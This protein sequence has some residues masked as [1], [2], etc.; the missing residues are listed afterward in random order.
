MLNALREKTQGL[1][2]MAL[3]VILVVPF[4]LWG[5]SSYFGGSSTVYVARGHGLRITGPEFET[6]L[7][8]QRAALE[9]AFGKNLNP[10]LLGGQKFKKAVLEG[11]INK[12]LLLSDAKK[13]G[14]TTNPTEL[15]EEIRS[16]PAF[17][18]KGHFNAARYQ[19]LLADQGFTVAA[20]ERRVRDLTLLNQ[21][22]VG[23]L[24]S[25]F[26]PAPVLEQAAAL[27]GQ[28][29]SIAYVVLAHHGLVKK[30]QVTEAAITQ[31]YATHAQDFRLPQKIRIAYVV[32][33]PA[34]VMRQMRGKMGMA[35]LQTA[36]QAHIQQFTQP[37][38]RLVRHIMIALPSHPTASEIAQAKA[39]LAA[40]R[41]RIIHG[42]S[43]AALAKRYSQDRASA[44]HGGSL[45][46]VTEADLSK[47]LGQAV[48]GL[49][50][51]QVSA[52]VVGDSG[53]HLLEVTG[54]HPASVKAFAAVKGQLQQMVLRTEAR[55]RIYHLSE[56]LRNAAFEHPH[57]LGAAA[58]KLGLTLHESAW[59]GRKG[60]TG[61]G[62]L[63]KVVQAVFAPKV[64]AGRRNTHAIALGEDGILVAHV[65]ARKAARTEPLKTARPAI[66][67]RIRHTMASQR[68]KREEN[69]LMAE[70]KKGASLKVVAR[71]MGLVLKLPAPFEAVTSSLPQPL[72]KAAFQ[73]HVTGVHPTPGTVALSRG[74][75]A[76]FVVRKVLMGQVKVGSARYIKLTQS[77]M[78]DAGVETYLAYM[79]S[80][81]ERAHVHINSG[82]L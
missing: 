24:A 40:L 39:K 12:T 10:A 78:K 47:P 29:R 56:R 36:Y 22:K 70:L 21:V 31:Y 58:R 17:R 35:A 13:A 55:K 27:F 69:T 37:A 80:L 1:M 74:R 71:Q 76:V 57:S 82:A 43:F 14:Y 67:Q 62:S 6:A 11:L 5:V 23:L 15:A 52:P 79:Q 54:V 20:F 66:I 26:V 77:F 45:G 19:A 42:A 28:K 81:R 48:F 68:I 2:G 65:I 41:D 60:G 9:Q 33:S 7:A 73:A 18:V 3:L 64:L 75:Q 25:A 38:E 51:N 30:T 44:V 63:P 50:L 53:V 16:I 46:Y 49:A 4:V 72:V 8:H 32:L 61:V 59:F 34:A